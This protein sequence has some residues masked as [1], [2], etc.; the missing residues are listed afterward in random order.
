MSSELSDAV[1][2]LTRVLDGPQ[3]THMLVGGNY[4]ADLRLVLA[5]LAAYKREVAA[6]R[7]K[8]GIS[9]A[10]SPV[11]VCEVCDA[12]AATDALAATEGA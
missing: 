6:W 11:G 10:D 9:H 8:H 4:G 1:E 3:V 12:I 7:A 5:A 2:R